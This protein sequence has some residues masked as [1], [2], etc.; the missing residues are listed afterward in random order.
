[1][2]RQATVS[3]PPEEVAHGISTIVELERI[4]LLLIEEVVNLSINRTTQH[5][6]VVFH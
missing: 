2:D 5:K 3:V 1:L 4:K 6:V